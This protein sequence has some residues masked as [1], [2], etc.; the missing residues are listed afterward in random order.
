MSL[1]ST[2]RR[3]S[4]SRWTAEAIAVLAGFA[5]LVQAVIYAHSQESILDEGA[6]LYKG[7]L[8]ATGRYTP[9]QD[10]GPWSNHM[11]LSFLIP[12]TFQVL[13]EPGLRTARYFAIILALLMLIGL[14]ILTKEFGGKWWATIAISALALNNVT[15]K[16][17]SLAVSQGLTACMLIWSVVCI[18]GMQRSTWQ[19]LLGATLAG[20]M[21]MTRI[22]M[23][24]VLP[25]LIIF[26]FWRH[27]PRK[28]I[29]A[30]LAGILPFLLFHIIY[31]PHIM[32]FWANWFPQRITPFLDA[33]RYTDVG[34]AI[35]V[36]SLPLRDRWWSFLQGLRSNYL[37]LVGLFGFSLL[38]LFPKQWKNTY[39]LQ[40]A[41]CI[42]M[43]IVPLLILHAW[44]SLMLNSCVYCFEGY[45]TFFA[46]LC[47]VLIPIVYQG[48]KTQ[49][50]SWFNWYAGGLLISCGQVWAMDLTDRRARC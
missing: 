6:Y 24:S 38:W 40:A 15:I 34:E 10:Y 26:V 41:A 13:I 48:W 12:G 45:M 46:P 32:Q 28:G 25:I 9:Y 20:L 35:W 42:S 3:I 4:S 44:A 47:L 8:F 1:K 39:L 14:W 5:Y 7:Y 50:K 31:W 43:I 36:N 18:L 49:D 23:A 11:P 19:I 27:G 22:N 2:I 17:Y 29:L 37:A 30:T 33:S 16:T 21:L